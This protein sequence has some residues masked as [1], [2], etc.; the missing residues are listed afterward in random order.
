[1]TDTSVASTRASNTLDALVRWS[2]DLMSRV[3]YWLVAL[4]T[5]ISIAGV[6]WQSGRTK[7]DGWR[8]S[9]LAIELFRSEYR[10]PVIDPVIAAYLA[11]FAEHLFPVMLVIGIA[12]RFAAIALLI[13][14]LI[15]QIFVYP[16]AWPTH[17]TWAACFLILITR[18]PGVVS[19]D[20]LIARHGR[21]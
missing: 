1:M 3:P 13:M 20:H 12:T 6:F 2:I 11:A 21:I 8:L 5:R 7:V 17:G 10:L 16:E 4:I 9:D 14:T 18:G 19:L 15:I